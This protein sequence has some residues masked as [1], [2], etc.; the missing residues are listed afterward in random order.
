[1]A[2]DL[3]CATQL[4]TVNGGFIC[5]IIFKSALYDSAQLSMRTVQCANRERWAS[6]PHMSGMPAYMAHACPCS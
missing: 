5:C 6:M 3:L 1:M 2:Q 4:M